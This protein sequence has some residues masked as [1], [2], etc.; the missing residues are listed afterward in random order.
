MAATLTRTRPLG[1]VARPA[2]LLLVSFACSGPLPSAGGDRCEPGAS[3]ECACSQSSLGLAWCDDDGRWATCVCD[4]N[5]TDAS[6][7]PTATDGG[8]DDDLATDPAPL[9]VAPRDSEDGAPDCSPFLLFVDD[10]GDGDGAAGSEPVSSCELLAGHAGTAT[11][12][13]D[14]DR[15]VHPGAPELCDDKDNDCDGAVDEDVAAITQWPDL[16]DDGYGDA[17]GAWVSDCRPLDGYAAVGGD[18]DD[19]DPAVHP[20]ATDLCDGVD[21]DCDGRIDE[22][23]S[24]TRRW[25]DVDDDGYGDRDA[26]SVLEC[27][28]VAPGFVEDDRD[29]DDGDGDVN[30]DAEERCNTR[31]DDCDGE[32]DEGVEFVPQWRDRDGDGYGDAGAAASRACALLDGFVENRRDCDD[33]RAGVNPLAVERCNGLDDDCDGTVDV[34]AFDRGV[35]FRDRDGD[36]YGDSADTVRGCVAPLGYV[37]RGGDCDDDEGAVSPGSTETCNARDDDCDE[38]IDEGV[39]NRCGGCGPEPIEV[40]GNLIDDDCDGE[41]DEDVACAC[42]GT[43]RLACYTGTPG[44]LDVGACRAGESACDCGGGEPPCDGIWGDCVGQIV[45]TEETC[46]DVDE[47][48]DGDIDEG[49]PVVE[50]FADDDGDGYGDPGIPSVE[51][52][53]LT[54]VLVDN[55]DDCDDT[56][57]AVHPESTEVCNDRDDDCDGEVDDDIGDFV[58]RP[59][60]DRDGY[61]DDSVPGR[62]ACSVPPGHSAVPGDCD[63]ERPATN[64]LGSEVCNGLDDDCNGHVDDDAT[65]A[66]PFYRDDDGD[67][68]GVVSSVVTACDVPEGYSDTSG[69]CDDG[70]VAVHPGATEV[71]NGADDDCDFEVDDGVSNR[72]GG[73]GEVPAEVCGN[74]VDDDCDGRIDEVVGCFCDGRTTPAC[75]TGRPGTADV[76]PCRGGTLAC[77]CPGGAETCDDGVWGACVGDVVPGAETCDGVDNDCDGAIDEGM[78]TIDGFPD[79]D[80]DGYGD[81]S[82]DPSRF[83]TLPDGFVDNADDCDDSTDLINPDRDEVCNFVDDDCDGLFDEDV[84]LLTLWPDRDDDGYGDRD[85]RPT[86][87]CALMAGYV[88]DDGD[89]DDEATDVNPGMTETCDGVDQDCDDVIDDDPADP[90]RFY[91]D[92]DGDG[93]GVSADAVWACFAP[94]HH[95]PV[96]GDCDDRF[97][98]VNPGADEVC[99]DVDDDCDTTVD[100]GVTNRC[101][102]CGPEPAEVC[103]NFVDDDCDG[104]IDE[105]ADGCFCDGRTNQPCYTGPPATLGIGVCRG[106]VIDCNCPG[107]ATFCSSGVWGSCD[108]EVLPGEELCDGV[109]NDCD[110][111]VDEGLRNT[112]GDCAPEVPEVCDGVDNDCDGDVDERLRLVCGVCDLGEASDELCDGFDNDCDGLVDEDCSCDGLT[113][114]CYPGPPAAVGVGVCRPGVRDCYATIDASGVC[115]GAVLPS[116]EICDGLDNDCDGDV[117]ESSSGCSICGAA[118]ETCDGVDNDCDGFADEGLRNGCGDCID[119]VA[120]EEAGGIILC[121]GVDNDCDG[122]VDEGLINACGN[123][124]AFCYTSGWVDTGGLGGDDEF[125]ATG[126]G[127]GISPSGDGLSLDTSSFTFADL[128][129]A[130]SVDD[131]VTRIDTETGAVL[132]TYSVGLNAGR[133]N[134]NPSRTAVDLNGDAWVANRAFGNQGSVT[135]I[136]GADCRVDCELFTVPVGGNNGVPRALAIDANNNAWVGNYHE[137]RIYHLDGETGAVLGSYGIG[138]STY[139]FTID[140]QGIIWIASNSQ[141]YGIGAFDTG[142]N[143]FLGR[144]TV[145]GCGLSYGIAVDASGNVWFG[146]WTCGTLGR[147]DRALFDAGTIRFDQYGSGLSNTRGVAVD[148]DGTIWLASSG[149]NRL[150]RFDASGTQLGNSATCSTPIGVGVASDGSIWSMCYSDDLAQRWSPAGSLL[151]SVPVGDAPYSYSDMTGFQ[152]RAFTAPSGTWTQSMDC[153]FAGCGYEAIRWSA[154]V[155]A[156]TTLT[157]RA[158]TREAGGAWSA[159]TPSYSTS[160]ADTSSALPDGQFLEIEITMT[161]SADEVTPVLTSLSV[162][163]QRP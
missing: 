83:C 33:A 62:R 111:L 2:L 77:D 138:M 34:G 46:D 50:G 163:W 29:C 7:T 129:V 118:A 119:S 114:D 26:P 151:G 146:T 16:D 128:W 9:D 49:L 15:Q 109:D 11:D 32:V 106:G 18:C 144:W 76:G 3:S 122:F 134:D 92:A 67:R 17:E 121:D 157:V 160:P 130:N 30:P 126:T 147:L 82:A 154:I 161:T 80:G 63:D 123:C 51:V 12:C 158:R 117:D 61:G 54:A 152:L 70:A 142:T 102:G 97:D 88:V 72:C 22:D 108:G 87:A 73:C 66:R 103:G 149:N 96:G 139:G 100:D 110:G 25:P 75:Y 4:G 131:T 60:S 19:A 133:N 148:S 150:A 28:D 113:A 74:L 112:C 101:G 57:A 56:D 40:C 93:F 156:D 31:D 137:Q 136:R 10:D 107:G 162:D 143:T 141:S 58:I 43:S 47:D 81:A 159:W 116:I 115:A 135:K 53:R 14:G 48:C 20:R 6:D 104:A 39:L 44:T 1:A 42:D 69:D 140:R 68:Y 90:S 37:T 127:D 64:P 155:P 38:E 8:R 145:P 89:C 52:C 13:D 125:E 5:L 65:D 71:C 94:P 45:P 86:Y 59:D 79:G 35:F 99:N 85:A 36:G 91:A 84:G 120:P 124:D 105:S 21:T 41:A 98:T 153:G 55:A 24:F 78:A 23:A 95:A 27:I 132:G